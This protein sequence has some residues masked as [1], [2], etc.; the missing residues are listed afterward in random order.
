MLA[1]ITAVA[2]VL[3]AVMSM[4]VVRH[5]EVV[6]YHQWNMVVVILLQVEKVVMF[7]ATLTSNAAVRII[8]MS[9]PASV[10]VR[11]Q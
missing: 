2:A 8:L 1:T 9:S 4:R 3:T 11:M 10:A 5:Q 7:L 6:I